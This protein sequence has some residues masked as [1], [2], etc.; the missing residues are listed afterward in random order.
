MLLGRW[1]RSLLG[2]ATRK[3]PARPHSW[4]GGD[5]QKL[6]CKQNKSGFIKPELGFLRPKC[7]FNTQIKGFTLQLTLAGNREQWQLTIW[8]RKTKRA[9]HTSIAFHRHVCLQVGHRSTFEIVGTSNMSS[10]L[11]P[12][13]SV[14]DGFDP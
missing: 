11:E 10:H 13:M 7:G 12:T 4:G 8:N 3:G 5:Q 2:N 14:F 1:S 9:W 6:E